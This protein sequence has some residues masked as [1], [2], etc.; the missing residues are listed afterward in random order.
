ML[1]ASMSETRDLQKAYR[2]LDV[3]I[4]DSTLREGEQAPG[5]AFTIEEAL[6]IAEFDL[7]VG[8]DW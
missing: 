7:D 3:K 2:S 8:I 1:K 4:V 5:V 6:K